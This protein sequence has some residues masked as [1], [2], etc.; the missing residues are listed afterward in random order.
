MRILTQ[1]EGGLV[2]ELGEGIDPAVNARVHLLSRAIASRLAGEVEELVPS[3]RS[4]LVL[5][6]PV[7]VPRERLVEEV[8]AIARE[9]E[10]TVAPPPRRV[11]QIPTRYGGI[12]GPDLADVARLT[13]LSEEEV[14][15]RHAA[16]VYQILFLGFTP[17]F[18]Y[19]GGLDP[20]LATPRLDTPRTRLP[21]GSVAIGGAQTGIYPVESPGGWRIVGRTAL[22]LFD[23]HR[24]NP[25]LLAPGDGLRFV[26]VEELEVEG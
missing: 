16:P 23:P 20:T 2:V 22:R 19:L 9:V 15:R 26:P 1:G 4:L 21:A 17:G 6:D 11:V 5:H 25:F 7:R 3:Y 24:E 14:V 10:A 8:L 13:G 12:H 18:P